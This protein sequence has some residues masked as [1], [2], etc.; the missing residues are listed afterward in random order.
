[1][2]HTHSAPST[3]SRA[4]I[5]SESSFAQSFRETL[6]TYKYVSPKKHTTQLQSL[7]KDDS[8]IPTQT[9]GFD[10]RDNT[11]STPSKRSA[12]DHEEFITPRTPKRSRTRSVEPS[13]P[14]S[15]KKRPKRGYAPP[16]TYEHLHHLQDYLEPHLDGKYNL[17]FPCNAKFNIYYSCILWY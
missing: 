13:T 2:Q 1:M 17:W 12:S 9:S 6:S 5:A 7:I 10:Y 8:G 4:N 11:P 3:P 16:E 14:H 15:N